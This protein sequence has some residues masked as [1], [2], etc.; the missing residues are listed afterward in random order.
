MWAL[1]GGASYYVNAPDLLSGE[2][3]TRRAIRLHPMQGDLPPRH[4]TQS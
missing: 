2:A 3:P 4:R 1:M